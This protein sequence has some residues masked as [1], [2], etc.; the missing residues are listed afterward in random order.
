MRTLARIGLACLLLPAAWAGDWSTPARAAARD[1]TALVVCRSKL[2]GD[3][4]LVEVQAAAGW[5]VYAMDNEIR[6]KDALAGRMSLGVEQ[7]TEVLVDGGLQVVG[8]WY[9]SEP[10]DFS[11]PELRWYSYGFEGTALLAARVTRTGAPT[12]GVT[13]RA[14]ACDSASCVSVEAEMEL[15]IDTAGAG[16]FSLTGLVPVLSVSD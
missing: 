12:A 14:Q 15:Q 16:E 3:Y 6:A 5:H 9:Q 10:R 1:G 4:L 8:A 13:V 11:Q 7:S 2:A